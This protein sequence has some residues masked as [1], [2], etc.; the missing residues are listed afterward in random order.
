MTGLT[1]ATDAA[2]DIA[3]AGR[4]RRLGVA[5]A[6]T[7]VLILLAASQL[8]APWAD[9]LASGAAAVTAVVVLLGVEL[10]WAEMVT[11]AQ[12]RGLVAVSARA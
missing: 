9:G 5:L 4:H 3:P 8:G 11:S 1:H 2:A 7:A 10:R 6:A 12:S